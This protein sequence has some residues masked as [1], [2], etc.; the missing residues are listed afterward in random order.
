MEKIPD[1]VNQTKLKEIVDD[2]EGT[3]HCL[4]IRFKNTGA[5]LNVWGTKITGPVLVAKDF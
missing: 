5:W 3:D 2:L 4:I 1:D